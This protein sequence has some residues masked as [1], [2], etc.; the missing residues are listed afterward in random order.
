MISARAPRYALLLVIA[1][2]AL[3]ASSH[4]RATT[5]CSATMTDLS[6]GTVVPGGAAVNATATLNYSCTYSG[7]LGSLF[8]D[9]VRLCFSIGTGSGG[10]GY[11]PR[12]MT[13]GAGDTMNFQIYSNSGNSTVWGGTGSAYTVPQTTLQ[14]TVLSNG[15]TQNGSLTVYGQVPMGQAALG[16]GTYMSA[17]NT[18]A[19]VQLTYAYN[20]VLL[21]LG[22]YP[23]TCTDGGT[24]NGTGLFPFSVG[25]SVQPSC[26][27]T[28]ASNMNFPTVASNFSSNDNAS[29]SIQMTC[30]NRTAWQVGLDNGQHAAGTTRR[31]VQGANAVTYQLYSDNAFSVPWG[32]T[33]NTNTV[34][35][36]GN[37]SSQTL[38][39]YGQVAPQAAL[40]AGS[41]SDTITV[42][43]TF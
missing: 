43:V 21:S 2:G 29:S 19:N 37:G 31:M 5:T 33:L 34:G 23:A 4:A 16:A 8:G 25:A 18:A 9:Y 20:E 22:T 11:N 24:G 15:T 32:N 6:F 7:F 40:A 14:F 39:V 12:A 1:V 28:A 42:M 36:T 27:L 3:L 30:V 38:H 10:S 26:S 13:S 35:G 41:Y 17:F